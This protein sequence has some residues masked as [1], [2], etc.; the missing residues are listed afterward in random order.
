VGEKGGKEG[1]GEKG[2][3]YERE[4]INRHDEAAKGGE[5]IEGG[6]Q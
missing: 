2:G 3:G 6:E 4:G 5:E 1:I